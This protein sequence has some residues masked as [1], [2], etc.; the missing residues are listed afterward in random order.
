MRLGSGIAAAAFEA[1]ASTFGESIRIEPLV[2]SEYAGAIADPGRAIATARATVAL[3]PA[4]D[5]LEGRGAAMQGVTRLAQREARIWFSP[6]DYAGIGYELRSGDRVVLV[7]RPS[8]PSYLVAR[9]PVSSDRG[10]IMAYLV[11]EAEQ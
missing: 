5:G 6:A 11:V 3:S 4:I 10:D 7:E 9:A 1:V 8:E 2:S